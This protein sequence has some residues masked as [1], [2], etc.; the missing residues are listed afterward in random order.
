[1]FAGIRTDRLVNIDLSVPIWTIEHVAAAFH[2]EVDT[3][4]EYTSREDF[5]RRRA[6]SSRHLWTPGGRPP[7]APE[8]CT[9]RRKR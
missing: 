1:M 4:H 5:P 6:R 7:G 2:L 3:A 8:S 9:P